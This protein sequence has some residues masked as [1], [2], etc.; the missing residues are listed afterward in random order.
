MADTTNNRVLEYNKPFTACA[1]LPCVGRGANIVFG[2]VGNFSAGG[3]NLGNFTIAPSANSL[4]TPNGVAID[5]HDNVFI[6]DVINNR[7]LEYISPLTPSAT[8]GSGDTVADLV[9]G[10]GASGASFTTNTILAVSATSL[11]G[12]RGVATDSVGNVYIADSANNRILEYKENTNPPANVTANL[13]FN[14]GGSLATAGFCGASATNLC[15]P[16]QLAFDVG[17]NLY[18]ADRSDNRVLEY[19]TPASSADTSA[20]MNIG[21]PSDP[22]CFT[23]G[24]LTASNV[25]APQGVAIDSAGDVFVS[26]TNNNR[27]LKFVTPRTTDTK[28]DAVLG[29]GDFPFHT[30]NTVDGHGMFRPD[31]I[32]IDRNSKPNHLYVAD[33]SNSRVLGWDNAVGFANGAAAD[34]VIGQGDFYSGNGN[35]AGAAPAANTLAGPNAVAVDGDGNLYVADTSNN[36]VLEYNIP[37]SSCGSF[38]CIGSAATKVFGQGGNFTTHAAASPP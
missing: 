38:P 23:G 24:V 34:L 32:A 18:V 10:Q 7:V 35:R 13:A 25:C 6:T 15:A 2:Q 19:D 33:T 1:T 8:A 4:C 26:D 30:A 16:Y 11:S 37:F 31:G 22:A 36:R 12:P 21:T 29:Q 17:G 3:C 9:F 27:I 5:S 20:D 14:T 28:A